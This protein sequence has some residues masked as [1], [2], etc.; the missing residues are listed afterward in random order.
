[1]FRRRW[2][3]GTPS[4]YALTKVRYFEKNKKHKMPLDANCA[5]LLR[6]SSS[7][8]RVFAVCQERQERRAILFKGER[9]KKC[10]SLI[11]DIFYIHGLGRVEEI[12]EME[13]EEVEEVE[14]VQRTVILLSG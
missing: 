7:V 3:G 11:V 13:I 8:E 4:S 9:E 2:Y 5:S 12:E 6:H 10:W 1:M 14:I